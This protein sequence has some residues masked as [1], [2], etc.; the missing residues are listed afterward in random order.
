MLKVR[1]S[2]IL[3]GMVCLLGTSA[4]AMAHDPCALEFEDC[5]SWWDDCSA[6]CSH[7][8]FEG[9]CEWFDCFQD[10]EFEEWCNL[11]GCAPIN[12]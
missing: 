9:S 10:G 5:A 12:P 7:F 6:E 11:G 1:I 2:V 3:L 8:T 4:V